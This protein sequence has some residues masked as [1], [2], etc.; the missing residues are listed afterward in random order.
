MR[1]GEA[2]LQLV[3]N[4]NYLGVMVN[5]KCNMGTE[6]DNRISKF[7]KN[8]GLLYPLLKEQHLSGR[9][10]TTLY[11]SILRPLLTYGCECWV[12]TTTLK[13][14]VQAAEM[15][16][17]RLIKGVTLRDRRQVKER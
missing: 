1:I 7:S 6:I 3:E 9:V 2:V 10:K 13:S 17:L 16:V 14:R 12:L 8:V 15:R 4:F 5:E 11:K